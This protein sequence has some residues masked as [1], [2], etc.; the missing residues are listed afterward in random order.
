MKYTCKHGCIVPEHLSNFHDQYFGG[1]G[2]VAYIYSLMLCKLLF[3][4]LC[5]DDET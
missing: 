5:H 2:F 4:K 3:L 1:H